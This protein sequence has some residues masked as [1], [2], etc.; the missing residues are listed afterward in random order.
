MNRKVLKGY[1]PNLGG[2]TKTTPIVLIVLRSILG[3]TPPELAYLASQ[4]T[5]TEVTQGFIRSLDRKIRLEPFKVLS[6]TP[7]AKKR[8]MVLVTTACDLIRQPVQMATKDK[9][10]RLNKADTQH[11]I[12]SLQTMATLGVPYAMLLYERFLLHCALFMSL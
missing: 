7:T 4:R 1:S 11:G 10:H 12:S 5:E 8:I 6:A 2:Q 3:F 9:I